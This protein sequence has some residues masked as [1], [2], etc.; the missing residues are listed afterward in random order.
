MEDQQDRSSVKCIVSV[1]CHTF[2]AS[3][4][5]YKQTLQRPISTCFAFLDL[6]LHLNKAFFSVV[7]RRR[8][9]DSRCSPSIKPFCFPFVGTATL[10]V[11]LSDTVVGAAANKG[12]NLASFV[13]HTISQSCSA[14]RLRAITLRVNT[15][16]I[17]KLQILVARKIP[18]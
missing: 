8:G 17:R 2:A 14:H 11:A 9:V 12:V 3:C 15:L 16:K 18:W 1:W 5:P 6:L 10:M 13:L 4:V 7:L